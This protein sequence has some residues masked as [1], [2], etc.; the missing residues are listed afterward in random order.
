VKD[1]KTVL[2]DSANNFILVFIAFL[3]GCC[4]LSYF[5]TQAFKNKPVTLPFQVSTQQNNEFKVN[6]FFVGC[7]MIQ[8]GL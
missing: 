8:T 4:F 2:N 6:D 7:L 1:A 3:L 5:Q